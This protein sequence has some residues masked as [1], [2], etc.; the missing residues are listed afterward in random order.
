M[1]VSFK[2]VLKYGIKSFQPY[3]FQTR[4]FLLG[5]FHFSPVATQMFN[6][7][8]GKSNNSAVAERLR[9]A[10]CLCA[11]SLKFVQGHSKLHR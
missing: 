5:Y 6:S 7:D 3:E 8:D 1:W 4:L 11:K 2:M 9:D 10:S